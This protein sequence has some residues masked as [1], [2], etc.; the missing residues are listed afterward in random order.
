VRERIEKL[1]CAAILNLEEDTAAILAQAKAL[2]SEIVTE[3]SAL[4]AK[5]GLE[6]E[7]LLSEIENYLLNDYAIVVE[8]KLAFIHAWGLMAAQLWICRHFKVDTPQPQ[9]NLTFLNLSMPPSE[10]IHPQATR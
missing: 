2:H 6:L 7:N 3:V 9:Q 5:A 8:V 1:A 10:N 4:H